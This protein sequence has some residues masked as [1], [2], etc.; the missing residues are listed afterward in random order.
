MDCEKAGALMMKYMDGVLT[1]NEAGSLHQHIKVCARCE[2]DFLAYDGIMNN[3]AEMSLSEPP[4]GFEIRVMEIVRQLPEVGLK[5]VHRALY[6]VLGV[7]SVLLGLG[8]IL[9]MNKESLLNWVDRYP[10]LQPLARIYAP[11]SDAVGNISLQVSSAAAQILSVLRQA[12]SGL[13]YVPLLLFA[14]LAAAQF[15]MYRRER[16]AGK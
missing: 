16:V 15:V 8:I 9:N 3:F 5:S 13:S 2:E 10:Q 4:E 6:G 12:G 1:E 7:F 14:L 11:I